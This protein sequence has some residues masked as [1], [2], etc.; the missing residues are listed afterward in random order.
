MKAKLE[1]LAGV[2]MILNTITHDYYIGST[3]TNRFYKRFMSHMANVNDLNLGSKVVKQ[4][5]KEYGINNF[6]FIILETTE[7]VIDNANT[8][9]VR[10]LENKYFNVYFP[11]YNVLKY[12][13]TSLGYKHTEETRKN[14][15]EQFSD[16]RRMFITNLNKGKSLSPETIEKIRIKAL[17]RPKP[18][19][20]SRAKMGTNI[21]SIIITSEANP[22]I[23]FKFVNL[24]IA[25]KALH[26]SYKT[27]QRAVRPGNNHIYI[28]DSL[29]DNLN[30][31]KVDNNMTSTI[32]DN[33]P[34]ET[35]IKDK[36]GL[37][38]TKGRT[39]YIIS[40]K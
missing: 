10:D 17:N 33:Y 8:R 18:S 28:P 30:T 25:A 26:C 7:E 36:S 37:S 9:V 21:H 2:Y 19:L 24:K 16:E 40:E 32:M 1:D 22:N 14:M 27:I 6:L 4:S 34:Y 29:L 38:K 11:K 39:K 23:A 12:A 15:N 5:I 20:E 13:H 31:F 35:T 3:I